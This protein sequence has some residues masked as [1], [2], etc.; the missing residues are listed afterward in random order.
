[1]LPAR[2][3]AEASRGEGRGRNQRLSE[4]PRAQECQLHGG[5]A[6]VVKGIQQ[7]VQHAAARGWHACQLRSMAGCRHHLAHTRLH[8]ARIQC[9]LPAPV[10]A[11]P[12][13]PQRY[14]S[15]V[16]LR[17][18]QLCGA[19]HRRL[20]QEPPGHGGVCGPAMHEVCIR[21]QRR[22]KRA[23]GAAATHEGPVPQLS[24][25]RATRQEGCKGATRG[26]P[27][28]PQAMSRVAR[29][30]RCDPP[31]RLHNLIPVTLEMCRRS[32]SMSRGAALPQQ[33]ATLP[34]LPLSQG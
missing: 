2:Q 32:R 25:Q 13:R 24:A 30:A 20:A 5:R 34:V 15:G 21:R 22:G 14:C 11:G 28:V 12:Q 9:Q 4:Q 18:R 7:R 29:D 19:Q 27:V 1:M 33:L 26:T 6:G 16:L 23:R 10:L 31:H 17:V 8:R 3:C